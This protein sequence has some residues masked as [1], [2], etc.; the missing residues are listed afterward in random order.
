MTLS[1]E[2]INSVFNNQ[3]NLVNKYAPNDLQEMMNTWS[4]NNAKIWTA[5]Q[6]IL[7][8]P[9][10]LCYIKLNR[11]ISYQKICTKSLIGNLFILWFDNNVPNLEK[12]IIKV[13]NT[14]PNNQI[15]KYCRNKESADSLLKILNNKDDRK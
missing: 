14:I 5:K 3:I 11:E 12:N 6:Y 7:S 9:L 2:L 13:F 15:E 8:N 1:L 10:V 4:T